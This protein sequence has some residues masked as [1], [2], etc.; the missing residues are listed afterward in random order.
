MVK[1]KLLLYYL[2]K[3]YAMKTYGRVFALEW[4]SIISSTVAAICIAVVVQQ[5]NGR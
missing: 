3:H 2:T 4:V 1:V 5:C